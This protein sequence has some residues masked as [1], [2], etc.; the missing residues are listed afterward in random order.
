MKLRLR[1]P[2]LFWT[3]AGA[4]LGVLLLGTL[5][6]GFAVIRLV[7][8]TID[9]MSAG[10]ARVLVERVAHDVGVALTDSPDTDIGMLLQRYAANPDS[11]WVVFRATQG[12]VALG[13][14]VPRRVAFFVQRLLTGE[15]PRRGFGG[16]RP[17]PEGMPPPPRILARKSVIVAGREAGEII[18]LRPFQRRFRGIGGRSSHF[19][20]FLPLAV[21][22]SGIAGMLL[23]RSFLRRIRELEMLAGRVAE[24]DLRARLPD[25][26]RDEIGRL[27]SALNRM[28]ERLAAAKSAVELT[29]RQR[30]QL[31]ADISHELATPLT[32]I[33]GYA[34]TLLDRKVDLTPQESETYLHH[35]LEASERMGLLIDDLL[36]LTRLEAGASPLSKERLNWTALVRNTL[37]RFE[38]QFEAASI[39]L[40]WDGPDEELW[41]VADG[42]RMEQ[43]IDNLLANA[44]R[45]VPANGTVR[46]SLVPLDAATG[47]LTVSDDGPGFAPEE[48]THVFE[49][50]F[51]GRETG[52]VNGSGL[53]LAIVQEI[54]RNHGGAARVR[55]AHP[56]G[57]VIE[58]DLPREAADR[59]P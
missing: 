53:G 14:R 21:L 49:R 17:P 31:F 40:R 46:V 22:L 45:Y 32:S 51:R 43:A 41:I 29:H 23:F 16:R 42:R 4:F 54:V 19:L 3:F 38:P 56:K 36:D 15:P 59:I 25:P 26:G 27:G 47:R 37:Q 50:F 20:Y 48:I 24:G 30:Q 8:S 33:R 2:S 44:L 11:L 1:S 35:V 34:E 10:S 55:N 12:E 28:T 9:R 6:Q 52:V 13:P 5:L 18:A 57:A 58:I 7:R 39:A